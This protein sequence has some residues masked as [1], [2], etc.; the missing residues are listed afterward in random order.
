MS[1]LDEAGLSHKYN[2]SLLYTY[3]SSWLT[4]SGRTLTK[5]LMPG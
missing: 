1:F 3:S 5:D 4:L 2:L